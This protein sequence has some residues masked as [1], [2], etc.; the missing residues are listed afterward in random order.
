M[1]E[2]WRWF[3]CMTVFFCIAVWPLLN[4]SDSGAQTET[5]PAQETVV[6][7]PRLVGDT[8]GLRGRVGDGVSQAPVGDK[9]GQ[10][11]IN[12]PRG[13]LGIPGGPRINYILALI[14]SIWT[15]WIFATVG[16]FGGI[17]AGIGHMTIYGIS[18]YATPFRQTSTT[19]N[20]A[21]TDSVR[22]SNQFLVMLA[23]LISTI[24][25]LRAK[26]LAWPL[27]LALG[28]GSVTGAILI[29]WITGGRI[30]FREYMGFFGLFVFLVGF[31]LIY[32][33]TEKGQAGKKAAKAAAQAFEKSVKERTAIGEQGIKLTSVGATNMKFTFFGQEF[34][35]NP[36]WAFCGGVIIASISAFIGV[37]GG[38]L[39]VPYCT[40]LVGA[41]MYV[42]AGT[43][44]MAVLVSM[45]TSVISY[46]TLGAAQVDWGLVGM[47]LIGIF[48][49]AMVGPY[50]QKYIPDI[51]L[52]RL[53][54]VLA[55]YV[56][57]RFTTLGFLGR[58]WVP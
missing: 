38:F 3:I 13:Y 21:L 25:Y 5:T 29:P 34:S 39:Y 6:E 19:L 42:V 7:A 24:N 10:I 12:A 20:R 46:L 1:K 23:S 11:D 52:K 43:S 27:G 51:W 16:A 49:G 31:F 48:I 17:S 54:A 40:S 44:A 32:E 50:T 53:F 56:G 2:K 35:F 47:Q 58:S 22:T 4:T 55:F 26:R 37:G 8:L 57:L 45:I 14:W 18:S 28:I 33:T 9:P 41:P 30:S 36:I 15:G